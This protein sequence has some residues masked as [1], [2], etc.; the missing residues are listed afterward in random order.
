[1]THKPNRYGWGKLKEALVSSVP[2]TVFEAPTRK[3]YSSIHSSGA[4]G[5]LF[6]SATEACLWI[7]SATE[8]DGWDWEAI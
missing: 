7:L 4:H 2:G 5:P 3:A 1:M 6:D 8:I